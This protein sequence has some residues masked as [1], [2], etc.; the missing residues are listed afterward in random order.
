MVECLSLAPTLAR[1][2]SPQSSGG[3]IP[4]ADEKTEVHIAMTWWHWD[5]QP[6][7]A[8]LRAS[9]VDQ[10]RGWKSRSSSLGPGMLFTQAD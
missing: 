7:G 2:A 1:W 8:G 3:I 6:D 4:F 5:P 10:R 9:A